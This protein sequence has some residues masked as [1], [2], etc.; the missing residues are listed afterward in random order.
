MHLG[1]ALAIL[2]LRRAGCMDDG[3]VNDRAATDRD[4]AIGQIPIDLGE[5]RL[6]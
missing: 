1:I 3:R 4:P 6:A 2:I 5:E